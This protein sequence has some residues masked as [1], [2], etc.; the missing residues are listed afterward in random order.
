MHAS[1][2]KYYA[3]EHLEISEEL[4]DHISGQGIKLKIKELK[5]HRWNTSRKDYELLVSWH[6]LEDVI[7]DSWEPLTTLIIDVPKLV[8]LYIQA[9]TDNELLKYA[10]DLKAKKG[11]K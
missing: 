5:Q 3:D 11:T 6:G 7:E 8:E 4:L 1:R 10:D 2:L 9:K